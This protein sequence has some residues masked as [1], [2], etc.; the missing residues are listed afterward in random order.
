NRIEPGGPD[1][2]QPTHFLPRRQWGV[3]TITVPK[4]FGDKKLTWTITTNGE[5]TTIPLNLNPLWVVEPFKNASGN[6]PPVVRFEQG[7][8]SFA[9]PARG[10]AQSYMT[11]LSD[12][13]ALTALVSDEGSTRPP[14]AGGRGGFGLSVSWSQFRGPAAVTFDN[15]RP[16]VEAEGTATT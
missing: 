7:A 3:F 14:R 10:I 6:A 16:R 4:D 1:Q 13:L 2:G 11:K 9:G 5:T 12:A 8:R 15:P